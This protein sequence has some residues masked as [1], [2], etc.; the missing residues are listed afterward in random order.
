M[1]SLITAYGIAELILKFT[2]VSPHHKVSSPLGEGYNKYIPDHFCQK[3]SSRGVHRPGVRMPP[4][5]SQGP[6]Q[7]LGL[8]RG[9]AG[10]L[11]LSVLGGP[12]LCW[13]SWY[14]G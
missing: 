12:S 13:S 5:H 6:G 7:V 3:G 8:G 4:L 2:F 9:S 10:A 11:P 14:Q 1:Y